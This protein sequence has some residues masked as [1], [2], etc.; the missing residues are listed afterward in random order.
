MKKRRSIGKRQTRGMR[1]TNI[2][3]VASGT[4]PEPRACG[5]VELGWRK[6]SEWS[7]REMVRGCEFHYTKY[8][9]S[10]I[11]S[12]SVKGRTNRR[13]RKCEKGVRAGG[14]RGKKDGKQGFAGSRGRVSERKRSRRSLNGENGR[15]PAR[16]V[17]LLLGWQ[18]PGAECANGR[19]CAKADDARYHG[20]GALVVRREP[21][22]ASPACGVLE[23]RTYRRCAA[24]AGRT[25]PRKASITVEVGAWS[26]R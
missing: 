23:G 19:T 11:T 25:R 7:V 26:C 3:A 5:V 22:L 12:F 21:G 8:G 6:Y 16:P 10:I 15:S 20:T 24:V 17:S 4:D 13:R 9:N 18:S 2:A 14:A 1:G